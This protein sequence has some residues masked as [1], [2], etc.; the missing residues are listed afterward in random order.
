VPSRLIAL[1]LL[2]LAAPA[3]GQLVSPEKEAALRALL[4]TVTDA[5]LAER[6]AGPLVLY[7][8]E[9]LPPVYQARE[10]RNGQLTNV[11]RSVIDGR[12]EDGNHRFPWQHG[13]GLHT[14]QNR[15]ANAQSFKFLALPEGRPVVYFRARLDEAFDT[16]DGIGHMFPVGTIVGEVLTQ[17]SPDGHDDP[18][19]LRIRVRQ[20]QSWGAEIYRPF[21]TAESLAAWLEERD[22]PRLD[23]AIAALTRPVALTEQTLT[24]RGLTDR[25]RFAVEFREAQFRY[26][27]LP[28]DVVA[29]ALTTKAFEPVTAPF[30][31]GTNGTAAFAGVNAEGWNIAPPNYFGTFAGLSMERCNQCHS[32]VGMSQRRFEST[33][34][35]NVRGQDSVFSFR[36]HSR[37]D[38]QPIAALVAA[39]VIE[40]FDETKHPPDVYQRIAELSHPR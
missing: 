6:L 23:S 19:E 26:P 10:N 24:D 40:A 20:P 11:L 22:D 3:F 32:Q 31:V 12:A 35:G 9:S 2:T 13:G 38:G 16:V 28:A 14:A 15:V 33:W 5:A 25:D 8:A 29:D 30:K 36:T 27:P 18:F 34:E 7:D 1:A 21:P 39:G 4:P 17:P 37:L